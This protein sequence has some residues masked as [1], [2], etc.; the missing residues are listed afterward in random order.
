MIR[1]PPRS[2]LFPYTTL[3]RSAGFPPEGC[4]R[5]PASRPPP[6]GGLET[7]FE[8]NQEPEEG[9][10]SFSDQHHAPGPAVQHPSRKGRGNDYRDRQAEQPKRVGA[11]PFGTG[12]PVREKN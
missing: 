11:R 8:T 1:P 2:T 12:K 5:F 3:F 7:K 10:R 9:Q 4:V 6:P